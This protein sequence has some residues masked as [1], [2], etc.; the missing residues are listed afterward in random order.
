MYLLR[1]CTLVMN[2]WDV[3]G[4]PAHNPVPAKWDGSLWTLDW[5][6]ACYL[7][8]ALLG[9]LGLLV[10]P[11]ARSA[12]AAPAGS[13]KTVGS[14]KAVGPV[15]SSEAA[16][17]GGSVGSDGALAQ[18]GADDVPR[19]GRFADRP[20]LLLKLAV[21]L[22]VVLAFHAFLPSVA[23][24][25]FVHL[26]AP[27]RFSLLF[28]SGMLLKVYADRI[29]FSDP[30]AAVAVAWLLMVYRFDAHPYVLIGPPLAYV[31]LWVSTRLPAPSVLRRHDLSYGLYIYAMP[32]QQLLVLYG[33]SR[34]NLAGFY[35]ASFAAALT[36]ASL[37]WFFI[38]RRA[39]R[40]KD[41]SPA[42]A[43]RPR[44]SRAVLGGEPRT[45]RLASGSAGSAERS[46]VEPLT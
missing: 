19:Q 11:G 16:A 23:R 39:L 40:L 24:P 2:M 6:F 17:T 29:P 7:T 8:V 3:S 34:W 30:L 4:T 21:A 12:R 1:N 18:A 33:V 44:E 20:G 5:E 14:A 37:S 38:E 45:A 46:A 36:L 43:R 25:V 27:T 26:D 32:A 9:A 41:Y 35:L 15:G 22:W 13:A 10:R 31:C 42:F 28:S